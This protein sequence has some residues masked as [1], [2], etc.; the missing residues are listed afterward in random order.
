MLPTSNNIKIHIVLSLTSLCCR[1]WINE[2]SQITNEAIPNPTNASQNSM[3]NSPIPSPAAVAA[4]SPPEFD[5]AKFV[6]NVSIFD[7]STNC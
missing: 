7:L 6:S 1:T 5:C 2:I 3:K 4:A